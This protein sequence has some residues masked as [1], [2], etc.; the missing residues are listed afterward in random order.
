MST[1][2]ADGLGVGAYAARRGRKPPR[3]AEALECHARSP[4]PGVGR[5]RRGRIEGSTKACPCRAS[6]WPGSNRAPRSISWPAR[7]WPDSASSA[8]PAPSSWASTCPSG[9]SST[10]SPRA[11][12]GPWTPPFTRRRWPTSCSTSGASTWTLPWSSACGRCSTAGRASTAPGR[13]TWRD[14]S[15]PRSSWCSTP[16]AAAPARRP[17]STARAPASQLEIGGVV[18]VGGDDSAVG[19][20][21][22]EA[23]RRDVG[24]PVLGHVPPQLTEQ[25]LRQ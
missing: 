11:R 3:R 16:A 20:E 19:L 1:S 7:C 5:A 23:L 15:T 25:F 24:L 6:S 2:V 10:T 14:A 22:L 9:V 21:L 18:L 13:P 4:D 8:P 12:R 17:P